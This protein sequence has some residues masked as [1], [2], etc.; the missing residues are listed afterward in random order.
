MP[1]GLGDSTTLD[2]TE[3][4]VRRRASFWSTRLDGAT[5]AMAAEAIFR[6]VLGLRFFSSGWSNVRRWPH[7]TETAAII[8]ARG[9]YPLGFVATFLMVVGG[10]ALALGVATPIAALMLIFFLIPT[11]VVHRRQKATL[12]SYAPAVEGAVVGDDVRAK[13]RMLARHGIHSHE[14]GLQENFVY[15]CACLYFLTHGASGFSV[16][17]LLRG[18]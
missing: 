6:V 3:T 9:A 1:I 13:L 16:D 10:A 8:S 17:A 11:F 12:E 4:E 7:A 14:T 15:L 2:G 18:R 5:L